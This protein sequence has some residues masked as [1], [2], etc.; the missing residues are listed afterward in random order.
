[1]WNIYLNRVRGEARIFWTPF[2]LT[3]HQRKCVKF[4][5]YHRA[6]LGID[7]LYFFKFC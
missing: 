7:L 2:C 1:V 5:Q 3:E 6:V 4:A